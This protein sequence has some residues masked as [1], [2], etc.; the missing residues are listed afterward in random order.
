MLL[1]TVEELTHKLKISQLEPE[2][3]N[4]KPVPM[5]I[6]NNIPKQRG[7]K[8][9]LFT[10]K[11]MLNKLDAVLENL[12]IKVFSDVTIFDEKRSIKFKI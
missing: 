1:K 5:P 8:Q 6:H 12:R 3:F 9:N 2:I 4:S 7:S 11:F 10:G